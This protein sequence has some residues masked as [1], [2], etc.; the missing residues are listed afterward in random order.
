MERKL[1]SRADSLRLMRRGSMKVIPENRDVVVFLLRGLFTRVEFA[2]FVDVFA[3]A[4]A[5]HAEWCHES[6]RL[7]LGSSLLRTSPPLDL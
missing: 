3:A 5:F 1:A 6:D 7:L 2:P 4:C